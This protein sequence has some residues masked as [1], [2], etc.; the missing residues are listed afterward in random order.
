MKITLRLFIILSILSFI[1]LFVP[2]DSTSAL[3]VNEVCG[4]VEAVYARGSDQKLGDNE[5]RQFEDQLKHRIAN[6]SVS[7]HLYELGTEKYNQAIY[8]AIKTFDW[9]V[10]PKALASAGQSF[11]YGESV[12]KGKVELKSYI[13]Q[14]MKECGDAVFVVGGYSQG[15]QVVREGIEQL[16]SAQ[17]DRIAFVALFGDP[18]LFLP[19]GIGGTFAPQCYTNAFMSSWRRTVPNCRTHYGSLFPQIPYISD[20]LKN[21]TGLWCNDN[22]FVCGSSRLIAEYWGHY[23]YAETGQAI[24]KAAKEA[25]E[26]VKAKLPPAQAQHI[27]VAFKQGDG[28]TGHDIAFAI[29]GHVSMTSRLPAIKAYIRKVA[30]D[31]KD[32]NGRIAVVLYGMKASNDGQS[33]TLQDMVSILP[34]EMDYEHKMTA[35]DSFNAAAPLKGS[36]LEVARIALDGLRWREGAAKSVITFTNQAAFLDPSHFGETKAAILKRALE[37]DPVSIFPVV[38]PGAESAYEELADK[39]S[40]KVFIDSGEGDIKDEIFATVMNRPVV[41]FGNA[42]YLA[43]VGQQVTFDVSG[44]Y[45]LDSKITK[46]DWDFDGDLE[47][48]ETTVEP[49]VTHTYTTNGDRTV[50][51]RATAANGM[52]S[53]GSVVAKIGPLPQEEIPKAPLQLKATAVSGQATTATVSWTPADTLAGGWAISVNGV[54]VGLVTGDKTTVEVTDIQR[55]N[56]V[57]IGVSGVTNNGAVGDAATTILAKPVPTTPVQPCSTGTWL[58]KLLCQAT[59]WYN[60]W[61]QQVN[62]WWLMLPH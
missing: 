24:D 8:P 12:E 37:I 48:E 39:S 32:K 23:K 46:Y 4:H 15:A 22:D 31:I 11:E 18:K 50:Q 2:D 36:P 29:D 26:K 6:N 47:F 56:D 14:R 54:N 13:E 25:A 61:L 51:V 59:I 53:N 19:E 40:G 5:Y 49:H 41:L 17:K 30:A 3:E 57:T 52:I 21:K 38:S 43:P 33:A 10:A 42:E 58:Q 7:L 60:L 20:S 62:Q 35:V 34:F 55:A 44:S 27:D 45:A 1:G 9:S 16:T 28:I